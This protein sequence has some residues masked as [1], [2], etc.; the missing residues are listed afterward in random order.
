MEETRVRSTQA[1]QSFIIGTGGLTYIVVGV[2]G[3]VAIILLIK[4]RKRKKR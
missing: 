2:V 4:F 3:I 1:S